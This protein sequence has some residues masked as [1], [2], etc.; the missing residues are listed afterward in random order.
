MVWLVIP[1]AWPGSSFVKGR[2]EYSDAIFT[3]D[4]RIGRRAAGRF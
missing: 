4:R 2:T 1:A 3:V